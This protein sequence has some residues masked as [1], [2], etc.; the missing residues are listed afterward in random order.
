VAFRV[1]ST[2]GLDEKRRKGEKVT[3]RGLSH[4]SI[5]KTLKVL[6]QVLDD[7]VEYGHLDVN[8]ARGKKRRLKAARP[9]RTWLELDEVYSL[10]DAVEGRAGRCSRR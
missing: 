8:P 4:G 3:E 2:H 5:N 7:A 10:L 9:K 6:A 1:R